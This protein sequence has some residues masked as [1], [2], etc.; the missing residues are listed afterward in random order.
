M[1]KDER[2]V[3]SNLPSLTINALIA[4]GSALD[5]SLMAAALVENAERPSCENASTNETAARE[6]LVK[7]TA[8]SGNE[9]SR[10]RNACRKG[11]VEE[12]DSPLMCACKQ[13]RTSS[14]GPSRKPFSTNA[15]VQPSGAMI[16]SAAANVSAL[17]SL[18]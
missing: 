4:R 7:V 15:A 1:P 3:H 9:T 13:R 10:N 18:P 16:R 14:P 2:L 5:A 17:G 12:I 8:V 11:C 6:S